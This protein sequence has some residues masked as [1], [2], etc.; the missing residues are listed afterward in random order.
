MFSTERLPRDRHE[1]TL[2]SAHRNWIRGDPS[3]SLLVQIPE[4]PAL[5][6]ELYLCRLSVKAFLSPGATVGWERRRDIGKMR[7]AEDRSSRGQVR[8]GAPICTLPG[9]PDRRSPSASRSW[10][11]SRKNH[12]VSLAGAGVKFSG[13]FSARAFLDLVYPINR[14]RLRGDLR[15]TGGPVLTARPRDHRAVLRLGRMVATGS[16]ASAR[17]AREA[18]SRLPA[19]SGTDGRSF[20]GPSR[21]PWILFAMVFAGRTGGKASG[22]AGPSD[23]D[24]HHRP[25]LVAASSGRRRLVHPASRGPGDRPQ[26]S[27]PQDHHAVPPGRLGG[28]PLAIEATVPERP[29]DPEVKIKHLLLRDGHHSSGFSPF[30]PPTP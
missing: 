26:E 22:G 6:C 1:G 28:V 12:V 30:M 2:A 21:P 10:T 20:P 27:P 19:A 18:R 11:S 24:R 29:C 4:M 17:D 23:R 8:E 13:P 16:L 3:G 15:R 14:L 25:C 5:R 9:S 7:A